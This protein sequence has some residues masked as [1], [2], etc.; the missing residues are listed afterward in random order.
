MKNKLGREQAGLA[1]GVAA[2]S[3]VL[4]ACGSGGGGSDTVTVQGDVPIAYAKRANTI[5]AN[6]TN[7][8]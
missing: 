5:R 1:C 7:G 4:A 8:A 3:L 6:P 2:L